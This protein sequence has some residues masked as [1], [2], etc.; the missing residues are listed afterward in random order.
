MFEYLKKLLDRQQLPWA[1]FMLTL[2]TICTVLCF[3]VVIAAFVYSTSFVDGL[4]SA[5]FPMA[6]AA[7]NMVAVVA[8]V[9]RI[10][11]LPTKK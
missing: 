5:L 7:I 3:S 6:I 1:L 8:N 9:E 4:T 10:A 11:Q 2:S